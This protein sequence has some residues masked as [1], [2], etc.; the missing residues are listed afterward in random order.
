MVPLIP[1]LTGHRPV[2]VRLPIRPGI[3]VLGGLTPLIVA[4][5]LG[6]VLSKEIS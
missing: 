2:A 3:S 1:G 6:H 5:Q 4:Q